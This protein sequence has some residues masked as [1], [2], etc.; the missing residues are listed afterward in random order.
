[1]LDGESTKLKNVANFISHSIDGDS[2]HG[3]G[4]KFRSYARPI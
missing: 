1:M 2:R 4:R 3:E